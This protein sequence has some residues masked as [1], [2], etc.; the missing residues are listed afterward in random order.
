MMLL[1]FEMVV[2]FGK[3]KKKEHYG[4]LVIQRQSIQ[5]MYDD[6]YTFTWEACFISKCTS[7]VLKILLITEKVC[8]CPKIER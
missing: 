6:L 2:S 3:K 5:L 8:K 7:C 1:C 4:E